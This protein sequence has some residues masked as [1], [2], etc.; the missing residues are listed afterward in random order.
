MKKVFLVTLFGFYLLNGIAQSKWKAFENTDNK[1]KT[2]YPTDW[3]L[4]VA[5]YDDIA[6]FTSADPDGDGYAENIVLFKEDLGGYSMPIKEYISIYLSRKQET[7]TNYKLIL[8]QSKTL[9]S[10]DAMEVV[11]EADQDGVR[12][13]WKQFYVI[14]NNVAYY[15]T[16][17]DLASAFDLHSRQAEVCMNSFQ[18]Q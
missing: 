14:I 18:F 17:T 5:K 8:L 9:G 1:I 12:M 11:Y 13:R 3:T 2:V 15:I 7:V 10:L 16:F 4:K 6:I